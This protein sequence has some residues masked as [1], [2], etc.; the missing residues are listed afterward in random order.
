MKKWLMIVVV[1]LA[2]PVFIFGANAAKAAPFALGDV[3]A[4]VNGGNIQQWRGGVIID[5]LSNGGILG[6]TTG[7]AFDGAG[8]LYGTNFSGGSITKYDTNGAIILPNP[9]VNGGLA[10][11]ESIAFS[12]GFTTFYVGQAGGTTINQYNT[13]TGALLN[14]YTVDIQNRGT[15]WVDLAADNKTL[16]YT[17]EGNRVFRFDTATNTQLADFNVAALPGSI[18]YALRILPTGEVLVADSQ[19]IIK[20][21]AAGNVI[22]TFTP[23]GTIS[24]LFSLNLDPDGVSFWTGDDGTGLFYRMLISDGSLVDTFDTG[25][26]SGNFFG[27]AVFGERTA[28]IIPIPP[29]VLLF[30][31]GL[32]LVGLAGLKRRLWG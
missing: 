17:S 27:L 12:S 19:F 8:N 30:G 11:P 2:L 15:D 14:S 20:L 10:S 5:T 22:D 31:S 1:M 9:F 32:G 6:F 21:D 3:F 13:A 25:V 26:G 4:G 16:F 7:M 29:S 23:P 24:E 18:A 28:P